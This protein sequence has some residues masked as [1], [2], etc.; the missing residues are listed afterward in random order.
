MEGLCFSSSLYMTLIW[1]RVF[2][3]VIDFPNSVKKKMNPQV[4]S[5]RDFFNDLTADDSYLQCIFEE[6]SKTSSRAGPWESNIKRCL[7]DIIQSDKSDDEAALSPISSRFLASSDVEEEQTK[8]TKKKVKVKS[9]SCQQ[10]Q[11]SWPARKKRYQPPERKKK[12]KKKKWVTEIVIVILH[13]FFN[14]WLLLIKDTF[15]ILQVLFLE[16]LIKQNFPQ[17]VFKKFE[18]ELCLNIESLSLLQV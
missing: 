8:H 13:S 1:Q 12:K 10:F 5:F 6:I 15:L 17:Q 16:L 2:W 14:V 3:W 18:F 9:H 11:H 4:E 7:A